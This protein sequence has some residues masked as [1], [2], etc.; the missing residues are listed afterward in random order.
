MGARS[1]MRHEMIIYQGFLSTWLCW[2]WMSI[3]E[4]YKLLSLILGIKDFQ[5]LLCR[6]HLMCWGRRGK[7][8][9]ITILDCWESLTLRLFGLSWRGLI[10]G[11]EFN[12]LRTYL[13]SNICLSFSS[14]IIY[15]NWCI[16]NILFQLVCFICVIVWKYSLLFFE[17]IW[18]HLLTWHQLRTL[19]CHIVIMVLI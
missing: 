18:S 8:A 2:W 11:F 6:F 15:L 17:S 16:V 10:L 14:S 9:Q 7:L 13:R 1:T 3:P 5:L 4:T 12:Q 19:A